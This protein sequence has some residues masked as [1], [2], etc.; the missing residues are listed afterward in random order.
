[1]NLIM[2]VSVLLVIT[3]V[4]PPASPKRP[5]TIFFINDDQIK[6]EMVAMG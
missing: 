3:T 4:A 2:G 6:K 1:M 5:N